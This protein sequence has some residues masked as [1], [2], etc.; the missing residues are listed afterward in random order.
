VGKAA[1]WKGSLKETTAQAA[2]CCSLCL[3]MEHDDLRVSALLTASY[4][5]SSNL[6][7]DDVKQEAISID[8]FLRIVSLV[9]IDLS[10]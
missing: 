1:L 7:G 8:S 2:K 4:C 3:A 6:Q 9:D 5:H 10:F